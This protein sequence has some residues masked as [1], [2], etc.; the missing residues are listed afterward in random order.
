MMI[1]SSLENAL[2][3]GF[4]WVDFNRE[5]GLHIVEFDRNTPRGRVKSIAFAR[6]DQGDR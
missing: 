5:Y 6:A 2:R 1:F 4:R 3:E